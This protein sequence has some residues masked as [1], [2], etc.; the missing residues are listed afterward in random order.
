MV[1]GLQFRATPSKPAWE[2]CPFSIESWPHILH[3]AKPFLPRAQLHG[4]VR[5]SPIPGPRTESAACVDRSV[6]EIKPLGPG[7]AASERG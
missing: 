1:L 5:F 2:L 7:N 3:T 6:Q 4:Y